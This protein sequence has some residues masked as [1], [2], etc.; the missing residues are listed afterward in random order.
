MYLVTGMHRSGTSFVTQLIGE[1][2]MITG[3]KESFIP[4]DEWNQEGYYEN[5]EIVLL[6][7]RLIAGDRLSST[8]FHLTPSHRVPIGS[9]LKMTVGMVGYFF[10]RNR[11]PIADRAR[12]KR[13]Q[14][15]ALAER[16]RDTVVKDP[17][18]CLTLGQWKEYAG[19]DS[20]VFSFRHP[21]EVARSLRRRDHLPLRLGFEIWRFHI[22]RF[23]SDAPGTP[24]VF[25]DFNRFFDPGERE[26]ELERCYAFAG[27]RYDPG[28]GRE[29]LSRVLNRSL[30]NNHA[31]EEEMP[32][33][34]RPLWRELERWRAHALSPL[35]YEPQFI[36]A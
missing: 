10:M 20:V 19:V 33:S 21:L 26:E 18:F 11:T 30:K 34:C 14:I 5:A 4:Q 8:R 6:N 28:E 24:M 9:R 2:G 31:G 32:A 15:I 3:S 23:L 25:V 29:I 35:P 12:E 27:K 17:R 1:I 13:D 36:S 16:Y 7:D 22:E